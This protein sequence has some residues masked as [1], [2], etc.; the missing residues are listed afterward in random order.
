MKEYGLQ[1]SWSEEY[2]F[3]TE[4]NVGRRIHDIYE[5]ISVMRNGAILL[6]HCSKGALFYHDLKKPCFRLLKLKGYKSS[7]QAIAHIPSFISMKDAVKGDDL[8]VL[9]TKSK[10][11]RVQIAGR[12]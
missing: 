8:A 6:F 1:G 9:N 11:C 12:E 5:P 7:Y 10:V 2:C 3:S 4:A